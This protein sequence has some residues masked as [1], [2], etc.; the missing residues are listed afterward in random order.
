MTHKEI[1]EHLALKLKG[2]NSSFVLT[3][4]ALREAL[5]DVLRNTRPISY[6]ETTEE[7]S[8][9]FRKI[10][11]TE[12][13]RLPVVDETLSDDTAIDMEEELCMAVVYFLCSYGSF[14]NKEAHEKKATKLIS[15]YD[16]NV[17][18]A[19]LEEVD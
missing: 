19:S 14:K 4:L 15:T 6:V 3:P 7:T 11:T 16:V 2:D 13:L 10:S 5:F 17:I 12:H 1:K 18:D 8:K 9:Y